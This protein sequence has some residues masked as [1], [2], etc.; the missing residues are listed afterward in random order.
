[1][2]TS[3]SCVRIR[4]GRSVMRGDDL[5]LGVALGAGVVLLVLVAALKLAGL[6]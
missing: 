5:A 3:W 1:M 4:H 2:F 6:A